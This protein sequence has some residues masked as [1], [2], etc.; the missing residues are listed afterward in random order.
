M[1]NIKINQVSIN[2]LSQIGT[3]ND[4]KI[5]RLNKKIL[6]DTPFKR[7]NMIPIG[8]MYVA[9]GGKENLIISQDR[10]VYNSVA[11]YINS[12]ISKLFSIPIDALMLDEENPLIIDIQGLSETKDSHEESKLKFTE[13][14]LS[15]IPKIEGLCGV[16]YRF[17]FN[18]N[19]GN[20]EIKIE[21]LIQDKN[22]YFY[23]YIN[24]FRNKI[25]YKQLGEVLQNEVEKFPSFFKDLNVNCGEK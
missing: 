7:V 10:I 18:N 16:G 6:Q 24:T 1:E 25:N 4:K 21:P 22:F 14:Y 8:I 13:K 5:E 19:S 23:E 17:L 15:L 20:G 11:S 2:V 3:I 9:D 12:N